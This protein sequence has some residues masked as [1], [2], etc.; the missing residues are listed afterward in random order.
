MNIRETFLKLTEYTTPFG[1]E[2]DLEPI[3][4]E[5]VPD[6]KKDSIGNYHKII[7]N[8]ETLFTCHL[9][10]YCKEKEKVQHIIDGRYIMTDGTTILGADNK[11]GVCVLLYLISN[12]VP[13]H[14]CFFVG[15]EPILSGGCYGS[16]LFAH[17]FKGL[18]KYK[19]AIAFD[20]KEETHII[21]RQLGEY[22]CSMEFATELAH[23]FNARGYWFE[24]NN[25]GYYTDTSSFIGTIPECT[26]ISIGVFGEHTKKEMV[27]IRHVEN[28]AAVA[29]TIP[30]ETL[31]S[32]RVVKPWVENE[33]E[34]PEEIETLNRF[35][36]DIVS[37]KLSM[38]N[39]LCKNKFPFNSSKIMYFNHWFK[40]FK[41]EVKILDES[42]IT[43][44]GEKLKL[45]FDKNTDLEII[46]ENQIIEIL[47]K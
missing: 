12:N 3:L 18:S 46:D 2:S 38:F 37:E 27:D 29:V 32:V 35:L 22:C 30:W 31:P 5:L 17:A 8:S 10:N 23:M 13:G 24:P 40:E 41:L 42:V 19:R 26:N 28:I 47:N 11:A 7:G 1:T 33:E 9:D 25:S 39:F 45:H 14:Y 6:L 44:N 4:M 36:F 16:S 15:E 20:R 21:R 43:L 34:Y